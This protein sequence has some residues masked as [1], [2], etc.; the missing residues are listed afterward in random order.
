MN[1]PKSY[2]P[3]ALEADLYQWWERS[4]FF[5]AEADDDGKPFSIVIPPPN[6][7][8]S[9]HIGH[10][11]DNTLQ[12][13]LVRRARMQGR[14]AVWLPGTDHAGIATQTVVERQ[15]AE[16]GQTRHDLGR[17]AFLDRVWEWKEESGGKILKQLRRLGCSCDWEREAFTFD[18]PR[19][20]AVR[21][22]FCDLYEQGLIYRGNRLINWDPKANTALSD[23]EV[24]HVEIQGSMTH[25]RYPAA[26]G[27]ESVV[28]A[29]TR[30]ETMLGDTAVAVHPDD[31]RYTDLIGRT[32]VVPFVDREIPVI[33]DDHVD[34]EFG[35]G[36]VKVTPAHDR[37]Q[38]GDCHSIGRVHKLSRT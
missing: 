3:T 9:L 38:T 17:E 1:L 10:A 6:V 30:P 27:G 26:D 4:G 11:L 8:G 33:A 35:T 19:S 25:F 21:K 7:T 5:H 24:D 12:D 36:A 29:T 22:V 18:E 32:V 37:R 34:P 23:I 14:N 2:D 31:E 13:V 20:E 16:Q 15:L 28:V